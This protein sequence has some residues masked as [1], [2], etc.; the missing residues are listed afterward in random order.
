[1][2]T[3]KPQLVLASVVA[4]A[5]VLALPP[6][7]A[8]AAPADPPAL[9]DIRAA[10]HP[11]Y[12]RIVFEFDGAVPTVARARWARD[13]RLDPSDLRANVQG[14]AFI[15]VRFRQAVGHQLEPPQD[16]TFGPA[17]R[18][19]DLPNVNHAVLLG[20]YEGEVTVG[21][22]LMQRTRII[23]TFRL[24]E[25]GRFVIHVATDFPKRT[26]KVFFLDE[27][28]FIDGQPGYIVP[29]KRKV[30]KGGAPEGVMQR[31]Y[32]GPTMAEIDTG[33]RFVSSGTKGFRDLRI[34]DRGI[35]RV[36]LR[37]P[38]DSGG[39]AVATVAHHVMPTLRAR[40]AVDWVKIYDRAGT[41]EE[42]KGR[43]DSIPFCLE[44]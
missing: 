23:K 39:S 10:H 36:T 22:G 9:V 11:G 43:T 37:G 44:P 20:D 27:P 38:C 34:N 33:L 12:D 40:P 17:R 31:L 16:S 6:T 25:P 32:A 3:L 21:I 28:A 4:I 18:S 30:P 19:F 29:V 2:L 42:P 8:T 41:T 14:D 13:L 7:A 24:K 35:A 26:A 1:M 5:A 15:K